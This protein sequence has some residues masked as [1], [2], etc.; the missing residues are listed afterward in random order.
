MTNVTEAISIAKFA[1]PSLDASGI[2]LLVAIGGIE[3][4]WGDGWSVTNR[5][6]EGISGTNNWGAITAGSD[7]TGDTF[8]HVDHKWTPSGTI[9]YVTK[10]RRYPTPVDGARD[11]AKLLQYQYP[12]ALAAATAGNWKGASAALYDGGYYSGFKP[13]DGAIADHY[14]QLRK[15]LLEQGITPALIGAAVGLEALFWIGLGVLGWHAT[16]RTRR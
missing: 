14:K 1:A 7:W 16:H 12:K 6:S 5:W 4:H 11:L 13:R 2:A 3:S 15:F 10:F 8:D 9:Q